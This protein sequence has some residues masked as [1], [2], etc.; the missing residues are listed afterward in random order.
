MFAGQWHPDPY[1]NARIALQQGDTAPALHLLAAARGDA[2]ARIHALCSLSRNTIPRLPQLEAQLGQ[3]PWNP[4]LWLLVGTLQEESAWK[5][6]GAAVM[7]ETSRA[8][9]DGLMHHMTRARESLHRAAE[10]LPEDPAPWRRLMG[11]AMAAGKYSGEVHD[12]WAELVKRGGDISY[13]ANRLRLVTL[14][15]KW[16]GSEA[17]CFAFARERTRDLPPGHPMHALVPLAHVE[18]YI[19]LRSDDNVFT[20][21]RAALRYFS[22]KEVRREV[23]AASDR[24]M[25]GADAYA[26]HPASPEA[27][28]AFAFVFNDR[29]DIK[30][31]RP[32]LER[33]GDEADWPW[34]YLSDDDESED[35]LLDRARMRAGLPKFPGR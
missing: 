5:A 18:A 22:R 6:R 31:S 7:S 13:D 24:L 25:A 27:H 23:D 9:V 16:H 19:E 17:E 35:Q 1:R 29:G 2:E 8:Q 12:M 21:V 20:R 33:S 14:T 4:D 15:G 10:L 11:C 28:Q 34:V 3:D 32:H 26:A 30:R